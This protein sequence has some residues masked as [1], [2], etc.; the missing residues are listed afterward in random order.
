MLVIIQYATKQLLTKQQ[1]LQNHLQF[2]IKRKGQ[3]NTTFMQMFQEIV[4]NI[5]YSFY[6]NRQAFQKLYKEG[7]TYLLQPVAINCKPI[8]NPKNF[9]CCF[10]A[11]VANFHPFSLRL[12]AGLNKRSLRVLGRYIGISRQVRLLYPKRA[13]FYVRTILLDEM[14]LQNFPFLFH[15]VPKR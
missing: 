3:N 5:Y 8:S 6:N 14:V 2:H 15:F 11:Y 1:R 9:Y 10:E 13:N 4:C 12:L 7:R